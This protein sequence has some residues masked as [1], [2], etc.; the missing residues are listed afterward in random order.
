[1]FAVMFTPRY[2]PHTDTAANGIEWVVSGSPLIVRERRHDAGS[3]P[4][5]PDGYVFSYGGLNPPAPLDALD[6]GDGV[7]IERGFATQHGTPP[8]AWARSEHVI[9]GAGLLLRDG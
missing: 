9:G 2:H 6:V 5:P 1:V 3:T 4:I 8:S 7:T